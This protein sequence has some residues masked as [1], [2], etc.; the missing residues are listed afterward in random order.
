MLEP[1]LDPVENDHCIRSKRALYYTHI[2]YYLLSGSGKTIAAELAMFKVFRDYP[3]GKVR[4]TVSRFLQCPKKMPNRQHAFSC[5]LGRVH[6]S[7]EG[8]GQGAHGGL[9]G[10]AGR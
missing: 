7:P 2:I 1:N 10:Q 3:D 4:L 8:P 5:P 6:R 9:E